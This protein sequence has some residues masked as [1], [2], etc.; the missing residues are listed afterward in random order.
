MHWHVKFHLPFLSLMMHR[1]YKIT[2]IKYKVILFQD[3]DM[4]YLDKKWEKLKVYKRV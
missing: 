2:F 1:F 3:K 4:I